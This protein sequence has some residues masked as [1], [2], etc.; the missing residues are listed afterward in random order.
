MHNT[1]HT[2]EAK[3]KM[4]LARRGVPVP[5]K[6]RQAILIEGIEHYQCSTCH[7]LKPKSDYYGN[8]R[9]PLGIK[10]ECKKC[11]CATSIRTRDKDRAA[12]KSREYMRRA[13]VKDPEKFRA[14]DREASRKRKRTVQVEARSQLNLAV[15]RGVVVKPAVCSNCGEAKKLV[16][17]HD[18]YSK[19]L[20]VRWLCY[21]CHGQ[22][23]RKR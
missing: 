16:A 22:E 6:R 18:D 14:R 7:E 23:H 15:R 5:A 11:H 12:D 4:S 1:P 21:I 2:D 19:P 10:S 8:T 17:H 20:D 9:S 3:K 13:K